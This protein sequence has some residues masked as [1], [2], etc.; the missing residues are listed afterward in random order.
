[1]K[2][3]A[4]LPLACLVLAP[5]LACPEASDDRRDEVAASTAALVL[6][7]LDEAHQGA[8][9]LSSAIN[10]FCSA[11]DAEH[12]DVVQL[13]W[14]QLRAP[15]KRLV[16]LPMGPL[17]DDG[18]QSAIDFWPAR[19]SSIEGGLASGATTQADIDALGVASKGMPAIEYLLWDPLGGDA[20]I[21]A[22]YAAP[23][24]SARCS[25]LQLV[26]DD[27]AL[28]LGELDASWRDAGGYGEQ[29]QQ[30]GDSEAFP[31]L[32]R[33]ID[34]ILN[35]MI[36]GLHDIDEPELG[37]PLGEDIGAVQP[38]LVES[39]FSDRSLLDARDALDGFARAY[40]GSEDAP[41]L[42]IVVAGKSASVDRRV[43]DALEAAEQALAAV[44]EPL[45]TALV[46]APEQVVA[47]RDAVREL[48]RVLSTEVASLLGVT[49][50]LSDNDGD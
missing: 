40:L 49:V 4:L 32:A 21:L 3:L 42:T 17:V 7:D 33:A 1:M 19:T 34:L 35:A 9:L 43:R 15:W 16:A 6:D 48:R 23:G 44:P 47:A 20:A 13:L 22:L 37:K 11:P 5:A 26:A 29:L 31:T 41:G 2:K 8:L 46:D 18:Y 38:D 36:A 25:Y 50:S 10:G 24:G 39:R 30:A 27:V 45:R 12:L 28:R 14:M